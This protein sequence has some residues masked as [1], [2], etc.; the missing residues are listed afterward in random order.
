MKLLAHTSESKENMRTQLAFSLYPFY[1]VMG[2]CRSPEEWD[3][4]SSYS[5]GKRYHTETLTW[6]Q[7]MLGPKASIAR[8]Q[9]LGKNSTTTKVEMEWGPLCRRIPSP[10][11]M[12]KMV[13]PLFVNKHLPLE[14]VD[15]N[16]TKVLTFSLYSV[17]A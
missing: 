13:R 5:L 16:S 17:V 6:S 7:D 10:I 8:R 9:I 3:L 15:Q 1:S 12:P 4:F 11:R 14:E 2:W